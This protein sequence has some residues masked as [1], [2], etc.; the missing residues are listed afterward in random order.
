[1][2]S[3]IVVTLSFFFLTSYNKNNRKIIDNFDKIF[4]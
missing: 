2:K 1:M 4:F 3:A